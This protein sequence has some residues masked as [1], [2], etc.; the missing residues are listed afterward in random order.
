MTTDCTNCTTNAS[1]P[2]MRNLNLS[3]VPSNRPLVVIDRGAEDY[4]KLV[5]GVVPGVQVV[6]LSPN[7]DGIEQVTQAIAQFSPSTV[8]L[9]AHGAPGCLY[10]GNGELSL[11]TLASH[12]GRLSQWFSGITAPRLMLYG[13]RV[14][15]GDAGEEFIHKLHQLTG[16]S[17]SAATGPI[18]AA[19]RGGSWN[20]DVEQGSSTSADLALTAVAQRSYAGVLGWVI[21]E[22]ENSTDVD[23]D[24]LLNSP[25][26][27]DLVSN[28]EFGA[29]VSIFGE[30]AVVGIPFDA[31]VNNADPNVG[32]LNDDVATGAL[33][34]YKLVGGNWEKQQRLTVPQDALDETT[35]PLTLSYG[36]TV[37]IT[38]IEQAAGDPLYRIV[39]GDPTGAGDTNPVD[40]GTFTEGESGRVYV[41]DL[42]PTT[43]EWDLS[44]RLQGFPDPREAGDPT[45]APSAISLDEFGSAVAT[46][47]DFIVVGAPQATSYL[48]LANRSEAQA[49]AAYIFEK[50]PDGSWAPATITLN[51]SQ[52]DGGELVDTQRI[53]FQNDPGKLADVGADFLGSSVAIDG[54]TVII[55]APGT[56]TLQPEILTQ[57][58]PETG[59][60]YVFSKKADGKWTL[61]ATLRSKDITVG[62]DDETVGS[63]FGRS[64]SIS[65]NYAIVGA[66]LE[67]AAANATNEQTDTGAAYIFEKQTDG[68]WSRIQQLTASDATAIDEFGFSVSISGDFIAIGAPLAGDV[69]DPISGNELIGGGSAYIF[70]RNPDLTAGQQWEE[71]EVIT[72]TEISQSPVDQTPEPFGRP[73][74]NAAGDGFVNLNRTFGESVSIYQDPETTTPQAIVGAPSDVVVLEQDDTTG[75]IQDTEA[76]IEANP[77]VDGPAR[78]AGDRDDVQ[79][80]GSVY[81]LRTRPEVIDVI[82]REVTTGETVPDKVSPRGTER[83]EDFFASDDN[84]A[85]GYSFTIVYNDSMDPSAAN[86]PAI[87]F[88]AP[89]TENN[90][91]TPTGEWISI[92]GGLNN[93][94][95]ITYPLLDQEVE[96]DNID[97]EIRGAKSALGIEQE[98]ATPAT[99]E[100]LTDAFDIDTRNPFLVP[101]PS[102]LATFITSADANRNTDVA[103]NLVGPRFFNTDT[104]TI[105]GTVSEE[106]ST[107]GIDLTQ[108]PINN[109][110][111]GALGGTLPEFNFSISPD[112][113]FQGNVD[114][115]LAAG[116]FRDVA[117]NGNAPITIE[118]IYDTTNPTTETLV[119]S[120]SDGV[121]AANQPINDASFTV[122]ATFDDTP[123]RKVSDIAGGP[124]VVTNIDATISPFTQVNAFEYTFTVTPTNPVGGF[125][126]DIT[127]SIADGAVADLATN[128]NQTPNGETPVTVTVN[129]D[130]RNPTVTLTTKEP[131][132]DPIAPGSP[133]VVDGIF[134]VIATFSEAIAPDSF[135]LINAPTGLNPVLDDL[136]VTNGSILSIVD[137][138]PVGGAP[139]YEIEFS[140]EDPNLDVSI[141]VRAGEVGNTVG[142][143][144]IAGNTNQASN[145]LTFDYVPAV[146]EAPVITLP[147][148]ADE[149]GEKL[150]V[151]GD[152]T[153]IF[154]DAPAGTGGII[155]I[156]DPD[157]GS[158]NEVR[159]DLSVDPAF[160]ALTLGN[161]TGLT[162]I[163]ADGSADPGNINNDGISDS[164]ISVLGTQAALNDALNGLIFDPVNIDTDATLT[165]TVNDLGFTGPDPLNPTPEEDTKTVTIDIDRVL[166]PAE[167]DFDNNGTSDLIFQDGGDNF[168]LFLDNP[169][170][171]ISVIQ[172]G[173]NF[174]I[175]AGFETRGSSDFDGDGV[176][177]L[178]LQDSAGNVSLLSVTVT[179]TP[180]ATTLT[181]VLPPKAITPSQEAGFSIVGVGDFGGPV[182]ATSGAAQTDIL[183]RNDSTGEVSI[184]YMNGDTF[185]SE[186]ALVGPTIRD[187][188]WQIEAVGDFNNDLEADIVW[189]NRVTGQNTIWLMNDET[190][191]AAVVLE[192][193]SRDWTL[194]GSGDYNGD[195]NADIVWRNQGTGENVI[196]LMNGTSVA[197]RQSLGSVAGPAQIVQ[198]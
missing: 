15:A 166:S 158:A 76:P 162:F 115:V 126:G 188:R 27:N 119:A 101:N 138:T 142:V 171:A 102:T 127:I 124:D 143:T 197:Q 38:A 56:E 14:A 186:V 128:P 3:S 73:T 43:G 190:V 100:F 7:E 49:G 185:A 53:A 9:I 114:V 139:T 25:I 159:L 80:A 85:A 184:W 122:T 8:H 67:D 84:V 10:L 177:E 180:S 132:L 31:P 121:I 168:V 65:G 131:T 154:A 23:P 37:A 106:L 108:V 63:E 26:T 52:L 193:I 123:L 110:T 19:A 92:N 107:T 133:R 160:G 61:D 95:V 36:S 79:S 93:A 68:S 157:A 130:T 77:T 28:E 182:N 12:A 152:K 151:Q 174:A 6:L 125:E 83:N 87:T 196:W 44:A 144:D 173:D 99:Q 86:Q 55:G 141:Q 137:V 91:G 98:E 189:R 145:I 153:L 116:T 40:T 140:P 22:K 29:S 13:C 90:L 69:Q 105:S 18:G 16:A 70:Q 129:Y 112:D 135:E 109:F 111:I 161:T 57:P 59:A 103:G 179:G 11:D 191:G 75:Q 169:S 72:A 21:A 39:V 167:H 46:S 81:F 64:V 51:E 149:P 1:A 34:V 35:D 5:A 62:E 48:D 47:E 172:Q 89:S 155:S 176:P 24:E 163:R 175:P 148:Q 78:N 146:N 58:Q 147:T 41:Y 2:A 82:F 33:Y 60:A 71:V 30:Y 194:A 134:T 170:G 45:T 96:I 17:I 74:L 118:A 4:Q 195:L 181:P 50:Q 164:I 136:I 32:P 192:S 117:G 120:N 104:L 94:Y 113:N 178:V 54:N 183:W 66:S 97:L 42:N 20:L 150:L 198:N 187:Q 156:S 165:I 88:L